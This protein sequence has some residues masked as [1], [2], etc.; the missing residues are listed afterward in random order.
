M[1]NFN[2]AREKLSSAVQEL[3]IGSGDVRERLYNAFL[4]MHTL[5][6]D[7]FP[8]EY[9]EDWKWIMEQLTRYEP[10]LDHNG[11]VFIGSVQ[12]TLQRIKNKTGAKIA[13]K[14]FDL[15]SDIDLIL[16]YNLLKLS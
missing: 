14:I 10:I 16:K 5:K 4:A 6:E 9:R 8:E 3:A 11:K 2:Y 7:D 1:N 13:K 15:E 12:N